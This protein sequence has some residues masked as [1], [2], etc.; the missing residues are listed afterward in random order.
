MY[1]R[2]GR[3]IDTV[4]PTGVD[5]AVFEAV[6]KDS[7][8]SALETALADLQRVRQS[9]PFRNLNPAAWGRAVRGWPVSQAP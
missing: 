8:Q 5:P 9:D 3:P 6:V 1:L 2:F 4:R 7:A